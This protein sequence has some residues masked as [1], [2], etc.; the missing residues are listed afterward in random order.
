MGRLVKEAGR[1]E[2]DGP[3]SDGAQ[4]RGDLGLEVSSQRAESI[5]D[6]VARR[7]AHVASSLVE[8]AHPR[9][10]RKADALQT[11]FAHNL[12]GK[13][14]PSAVSPSRQPTPTHR[15]PLR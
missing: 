2:E 8:Q 11:S 9:D 6:L 7:S 13:S 14:P 3:S 15:G 4:A 10:P 1:I 5:D 12:W